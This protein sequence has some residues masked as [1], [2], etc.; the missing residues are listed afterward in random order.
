VNR[1]V[2]QINSRFVLFYTVPFIGKFA[3]YLLDAGGLAEYVQIN[4]YGKTR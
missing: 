1:D 3:L 4:D 2:K